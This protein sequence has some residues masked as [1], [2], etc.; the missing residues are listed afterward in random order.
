MREERVSLI[1][2]TRGV[3]CLPASAVA[4]GD[5]MA[6]LGSRRDGQYRENA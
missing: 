6:P 5:V 2:P 1:L 4:E 3:P